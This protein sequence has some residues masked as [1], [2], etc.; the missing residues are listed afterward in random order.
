MLEVVTADQKPAT[1][2]PKNHGYE[3]KRKITAA[4]NQTLHLQELAYECA[5]ELR[6]QA[7]S[8]EDGLTRDDAVAIASLIR[9][10]DTMVDRVRKIRGKSLPG[11][12]KPVEAK[13]KKAKPKNLPPV[14]PE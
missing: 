5:I 12:A 10:Y 11:P 14:V 9:G 1:P 4:L 7:R 13:P 2:I 6:E 3:T 8:S